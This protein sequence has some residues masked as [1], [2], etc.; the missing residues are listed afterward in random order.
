MKAQ[1]S[2][3]MTTGLA[4]M[5]RTSLVWLEHVNVALRPPVSDA[6]SRARRGLDNT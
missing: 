3:T 2:V 4:I 1:G 5:L 6:A